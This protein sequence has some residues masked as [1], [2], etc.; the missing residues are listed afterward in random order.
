MVKKHYATLTH[1]PISVQTLELWCTTRRNV[2]LY[3]CV[4]YKNISK[5]VTAIREPL[6]AANCQFSHPQY[7][8]SDLF[9][10][11]IFT[12]NPNG[13]CFHRMSTLSPR[14][15]GTGSY[16]TTKRRESKQCFWV[17][18]SCGYCQKIRFCIGDIWDQCLP[19]LN[20]VT[21]ANRVISN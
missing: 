5:I 4:A 9:V 3:Q 13:C 15:A 6:C 12:P 19:P 17:F 1:R 16:G 18:A 7:P 21:H 10:R 11:R 20:V 2:Q 8:I 14:R